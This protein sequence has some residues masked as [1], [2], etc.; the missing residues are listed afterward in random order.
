MWMMNRK[1]CG[2]QV[3]SLYFVLCRLSSEPVQL[4]PLSLSGKRNTEF[5]KR[6][7]RSRDGNTSV[8]VIGT[9]HQ[10]TTTVYRLFYTM[11]LFDILHPSCET[12]RR[13]EL[14]NLLAIRC[15]NVWP[16]ML[17]VTKCSHGNQLKLSSCHTHNM[18]PHPSST[19]IYLASEWKSGSHFGF[20]RA[21]K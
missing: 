13:H 21:R 3:L 4:S 2:R 16:P 15:Q 12:D 7:W 14:L 5:P 1:G 18:H 6:F 11:P 19:I 9:F 17:P 10:T 8:L 20:Y